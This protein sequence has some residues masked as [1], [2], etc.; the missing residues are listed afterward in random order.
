MN[1]SADTDG[2]SSGMLRFP[3]QAVALYRSGR[4]QE[5]E[6]ICAETAERE[7]GNFDALHMLGALQSERGDWA[8]A[9]VQFERAARVDDRSPFLQ[10]SL[11]LALHA[12]DRPLEAVN[13]FRRA[14]A[15]LPAFAEAHCN[16]SNVLDELGRDDEA[17]ECVQTAIAFQPE[18]ARAH[19]NRGSLLQKHRRLQEALGSYD[20]A[21][22]IAA[23]YA[24]A[25][26]KR[27]ALLVEMGRTSDALASFDR[28]LSADPNDPLAYVN[29]SALYESLSRFEDSL[30]DAERAAEARPDSAIAHNARGSALVRLGRHAEALACFRRAMRLDARWAEAHWNASLCLLRLGELREGWKLF[31]WRKRLPRPLGRRSFSAQEWLGGE[32]LDGQTLLLYAEQGLGDTIHFCRYVTRAARA[33]ARVLLEVPPQLKQLMSSVEGVEQVFGTGE[34]LPSFDRFCALMSLPLAFDTTLDDVPR[35]MPYLRCD[36][37]RAQLWRQ[38]LAVGVRHK[39]RVGLVWATGSRPWLPAVSATN[40]RRNVPLAQFTGLKHPEVEF[41]SLQ[42]GA[43]AEQE[44]AQIRA[45]GWD[46]PEIQDLAPLLHDFSDTAAVIENLDLLISVDTA[47]AH[48]A[49]ALGKPVSILLSFD[50]CW[51]WQLGR[52]DSPWYP[53]AKLYRQSTAGN[54]SAVLEAVKDD[55]SVRVSRPRV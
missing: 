16:L 29:R 25:H 53:T 50:S 27:G 8:E 42:K 18:L 26:A 51:R 54:W 39:W 2:P 30:A 34:P 5:A 55:L 3:D 4:R 21:I 38:R 49:G 46:G 6:R 9:L 43:A 47:T 7:P 41:Y 1:P 31:E 36:A 24:T 44:L 10:N 23:G 11:G 32:S 12:L 52:D 45:S 15:L 28:A 40:A 14:I 19:S 20:Q 13:H 33:G 22:V 35:Q 17:L 37:S 48:L